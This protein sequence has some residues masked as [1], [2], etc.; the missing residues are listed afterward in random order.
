MAGA[1]GAAGEAIVTE[2]LIASLND[3]SVSVPRSLCST[4]GARGRRRQPAG[5]HPR[6][7]RRLLRR[8]SH[9]T[10]ARPSR[11][12]R[13]TARA[14]SCTRW[15]R[16]RSGA[17]CTWSASRSAC[18]RRASR[19][20]RATRPARA[21]AR[22]RCSWSCSGARPLRGRPPTSPG[23]PPGSHARAA[24]HATA[25]ATAGAP[26]KRGARAQGALGADGGRR[27]RARPPRGAVP[28]P[29]PEAGAGAARSGRLQEA[30]CLLR[31]CRAP[32]EATAHLAAPGRTACCRRLDACC[33]LHGAA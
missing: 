21:T 27:R 20:A 13:R 18:A 23:S 15:P 4:S 7:R 3:G 16:R 26:G 30:G 32:P 12:S 29:V 1:P 8:W 33:A 19:A 25:V 2:Q 28:G 11:A 5:R 31:G 14:P 10:W 6:A 9:P 22:R 24:W 17:A